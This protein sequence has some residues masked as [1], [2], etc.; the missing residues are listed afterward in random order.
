MARQEKHASSRRLRWT[1][2]GLFLV[3]LVLSLLMASRGQLDGDAL[4]LLARGWLWVVEGKFIPYGNR[5]SSGGKSPGGVTTLLVGLP[6]WLWSD[7]RAPV[8]VIVGFHVLAYL[9]LVIA[10]RDVL[11]RTERLFLSLLYWLSPWR[12]YHSGFL[13]NP[14]YLFLFGAL[15]LWSARRLQRGSDAWASLVHGLALVLA[16]QLHASAAL[17]FGASFVLYLRRCLRPAWPALMLG[18]LIGAIPLIPWAIE[19]RTHPAIVTMQNGFPGRG[20][21]LVHPL[22]RGLLY[23]LRYASLNVVEDM[24]TLDFV[25]ALGPVSDVI[26]RWTLGFVTAVIGPFTVVLALVAWLQ[27]FRTERHRPWRCP[28]PS[29][30]DGR[31][32]LRTYVVSCFLG[33]ALIFAVDPTTPMHWQGFVVFHVA[34]LAPVL[35]LGELTRSRLARPIMA[36]VLVFAGLGLL[37]TLGMAF[38]SNR[39]RCGGRLDLNRTLRADHPMLHQLH[40]VD[41]CPYPIDPG[42]YWPDVF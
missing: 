29:T 21:L 27:L 18:A 32:W 23:I 22:V 38:G 6:L 5:M 4:D 28:E 40:V 37:T 9:I 13:W 25:G 31:A 42:G 34:I 19:V 36:G 30:M 41:R 26:A 12:I 39:Y 8:G 11:T 14:N 10:L 24:R 35:W 3:G 17:L 7:A 16:F 2:I 1:L 20:L 15:H 33:A